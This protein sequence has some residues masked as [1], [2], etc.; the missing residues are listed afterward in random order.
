MIQFF[1]QNLPILMYYMQLTATTAE[2]TVFGS[3]F[4]LAVEHI[5]GRR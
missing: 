3:A 1:L 4:G 5:D 2:L